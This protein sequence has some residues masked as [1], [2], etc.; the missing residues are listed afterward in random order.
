MNFNKKQ[1]KN[2]YQRF[3]VIMGAVLIVLALVWLAIADVRIY[4]K[5]KE[6]NLQVENLQKKVQDLKS[7]NSNL[8]EGTARSFDDVYIE[9]VAREELDLQKP[10]EKVFSFVQTS[11][12]QQNNVAPK[13]DWQAWVGGA[14]GSFI[15]I[16]KK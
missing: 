6:L 10:D 16:F 13:N 8:K 14:W 7:Q 9:K 2:Q 5:K 3:F 15:S 11:P 1:N 12:Q 4:Q